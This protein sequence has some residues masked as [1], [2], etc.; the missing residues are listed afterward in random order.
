MA[1]EN[2][3]SLVTLIDE[4]GNERQFEHIGTIDYEGATYVALVP[5]DDEL[6]SE[7]SMQ[8][9]QFVI[10]RLATDEKTGEEILEAVEDDDELDEIAGQFEEMLS[11]EYDIVDEDDSDTDDENDGSSSDPS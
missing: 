6:L 1:E 5:A 8:E 3:D 11:S 4:E 10:L 7:N 9:G 2:S